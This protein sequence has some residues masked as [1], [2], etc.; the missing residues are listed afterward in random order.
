MSSCLW[1]FQNFFQGGGTKF[2]H[3]SNVFFLAKIF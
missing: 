2:C 1:R 3:I